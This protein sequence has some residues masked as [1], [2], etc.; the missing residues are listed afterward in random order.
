MNLMIHKVIGKTLG[1][2]I[3]LDLGDVGAGQ[4][5]VDDE[6]AYDASMKRWG[7]MV[8]SPRGCGVDIKQT[9]VT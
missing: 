1:V 5:N 9:S 4:Y 2:F 8:N 7:R 6:D 3:C